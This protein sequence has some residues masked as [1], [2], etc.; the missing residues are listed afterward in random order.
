[1][2]AD[3]GSDFKNDAVNVT[4]DLQVARGLRQPQCKLAVRT[5]VPVDEC[6]NR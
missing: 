3:L 1:M 2:V 6:R 5:D 4:P